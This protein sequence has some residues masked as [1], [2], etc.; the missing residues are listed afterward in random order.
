MKAVLVHLDHLEE[1]RPTA[2]RTALEVVPK[3]VPIVVVGHPIDREVDLA[4]AAIADLV[5]HL[6]VV[7]SCSGR[8]SIAAEDQVVVDDL[9]IAVDSAAHLVADDD[10]PTVVG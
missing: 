5:E 1:E 4:V 3:E 10:H 2:D 9:P 8:Y 6:E 7:Q